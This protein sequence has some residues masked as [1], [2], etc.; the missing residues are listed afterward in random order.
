M[1]VTLGRVR[2][3]VDEKETAGKAGSGE[4]WGAGAEQGGREGAGVIPSISPTCSEAA[5]EP[6][7]A[8]S[9]AAEAV[10][11]RAC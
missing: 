4:V 6:S 9:P 8:R 3:G 10:N 7:S 2:V 11:W 1:L 5:M